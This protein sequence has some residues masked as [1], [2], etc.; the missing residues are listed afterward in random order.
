MDAGF[1][2]FERIVF[3]TGA[4]LSRESG[5]PTYRGPGGI[6]KD[7]QY[8]SVACQDAFDRDPNVVWEFHN[9]RRSI[10]GSAEPSLGHSIIAGLSEKKEVSVI[11]QNID[12]LHQ[13]AGTRD[14]IEL[15]GS[16]WRVR[17]DVCGSRRED[18]DVPFA[19]LKCSGCGTYWRPDI[20]WFGD[21][22]RGD[23]IEAAA[24]AL[25]TCDLL[26][27]VGTSAVVYPAAALPE[28]AK[29]AGA[30]CVE[31]NPEE[32]PMSDMYDVQFRTTANEALDRLANG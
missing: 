12:G 16:L 26:V 28:I 6:W 2:A 3:F 4:G 1:D 27:S 7:Y 21:A 25:S 29:A 10:V 17:C 18:R 30:V 9:Y 23:A 31:I 14:V 24:V 20:V 5:V 32:T 19:P 11:T 8:E 22:L 13:L 15:H